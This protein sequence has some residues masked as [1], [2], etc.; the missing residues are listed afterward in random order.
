MSKREYVE[1]MQEDFMW[2]LK[3]WGGKDNSDGWKKNDICKPLTL[4]EKLV[5]V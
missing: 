4:T 3:V 2:I 1:F 5:K